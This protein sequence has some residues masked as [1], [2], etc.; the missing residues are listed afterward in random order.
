MAG[1]LRRHLDGVG[2]RRDV[3]QRPVEV[4]EERPVERGSGAAAT[5]S[6][7]RVPGS[8]ARSPSAV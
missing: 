8:P 2:R 3:Q 6:G 1:Q 7:M 5:L 4:K